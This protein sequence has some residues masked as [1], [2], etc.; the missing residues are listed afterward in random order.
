MD[1]FRFG[2][3]GLGAG[4]LLCC[5]GVADEP[6]AVSNAGTVVIGSVQVDAQ[7]RT[8]LAPGWVNQQEGPIELLAC[9]KRGKTHESVFVLDVNPLD[10]QTGLLLLGLK[11]GAPMPGLGQGPPQGDALDLWVE[12]A[13]GETN[14]RERA[15]FFVYDTESH[16]VLP[17]TPWVF[18]GSMME[19]GEFKAMAEESLVA[20][21]WDPWA[22][23]N[24]ALPCGANDEF[25]MVNTNLAP[26]VQTPV[27]LHFKAR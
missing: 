8:V 4:V 12:W 23:V 26:A 27:T 17:E 9:G 15:E 1:A 6:A 5:G 25:L 24:M 10:L 13:D 3:A 16:A 14:R 18:T 22:I 11:F 21:Y 7:T 2:L 20:T 19:A